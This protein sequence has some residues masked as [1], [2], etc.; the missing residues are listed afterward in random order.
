MI[1]SI[2]SWTASVLLIAAFIPQI[3]RIHK[4]KEV[5]DL[6]VLSFWGLLLGSLG[7][8]TEA[9]MVGSGP[10]FFKQLLTALCAIIILVQIKTHSKDKWED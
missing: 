4:H 9:Y 5:R 10:L 1:I 7:L 6:S 8:A 3:W 2:I